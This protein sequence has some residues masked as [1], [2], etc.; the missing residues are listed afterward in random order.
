[1][2]TLPNYAKHLLLHGASV[3]GSFTQGYFFVEERIKSQHGK[4]LQDFCQWIDDQ[5]GGAGFN[6]IDWL[7]LAFKNPAHTELQQRVNDLRTRI[8]Q[9]RSIK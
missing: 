5:I 6:N 8:A 7:F 2:Q 9:I 4:F 1:M 3:T